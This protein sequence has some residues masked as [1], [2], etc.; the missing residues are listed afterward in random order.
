VVRRLVDSRSATPLSAAVEAAAN[1]EP[2][3]E[4]RIT[5]REEVEQLME[6]LDENEATVVR[7]YHLEGKSYQEISR[8]TGLATNSVG[9]MLSRARTKLREV[10]A[11]R[12][13]A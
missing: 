1:H 3:P 11:R 5:D 13:H 6:Q 10:C 8:S 12:S 7:M 2:S 4:Q 9:P